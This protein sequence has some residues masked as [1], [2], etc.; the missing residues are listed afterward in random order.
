MKPSPGMSNTT[1]ILVVVVIILVAAIGIAA[2]MILLTKE[3]LAYNTTNNT[4]ITGNFT[5]QSTTTTDNQTKSSGSSDIENLGV[6]G[7]DLN[8]YQLVDVRR[9]SDTGNVRCRLCREWTVQRTVYEY[10]NSAGEMV[11]IGENY[12]TGCGGTCKDYW[13]KGEW[14]DL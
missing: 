4:N 2:V 11:M 1:R 13:Q 3:P 9:S 7:E 14:S 12:C 8:G 10:E 6:N 5:P